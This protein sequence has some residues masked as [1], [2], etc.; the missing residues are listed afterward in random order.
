MEA[1]DIPRRVDFLPVGIQGSGC[2]YSDLEWY[3]PASSGGTVNRLSGTGRRVS[4]RPLIAWRCQRD[5]QDRKALA[6]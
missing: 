4:V 6:R 3:G 5:E 2:S 1:A